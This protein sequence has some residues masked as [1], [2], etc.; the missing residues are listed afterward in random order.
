LGYGFSMHSEALGASIAADCGLPSDTWSPK[1]AQPD[2]T[3]CLEL[4]VFRIMK[5]CYSM[6]TTVSDFLHYGRLASY[7][8]L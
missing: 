5:K 2:H 6:T 7:I 8:Q 3:Q 1:K 4:D